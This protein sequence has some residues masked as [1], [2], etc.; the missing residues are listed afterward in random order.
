[1]QR[2]KLSLAGIPMSFPPINIVGMRVRVE[3]HVFW[4]GNVALTVKSPDAIA[5]VFRNWWR[6]GCGMKGCPSRQAERH[7]GSYLPSL[8]QHRLFR[9]NWNLDTPS[10]THGA[11]YGEAAGP[12]QTSLLENSATSK[13]TRTIAEPIRPGFSSSIVG[14]Q[15]NWCC[16][17]FMGFL[18][19]ES[20]R[21]LIVMDGG[22]G[23]MERCVESP[24][25]HTSNWA[26]R[27]PRFSR[28]API[29][30]IL[31]PSEKLKLS[32]SHVARGHPAESFNSRN[33]ANSYESLVQ[34]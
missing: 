23:F 31:L 10:L 34:V 4:L 8:Q 13:A 30:T 12:R 27:L 28:G 6:G 14:P 1:M 3:I 9:S 32:F 29:R 2:S 20:R 15:V 19:Q 33:D 5:S 24:P 11:F 16:D 18:S 25:T 21:C 7:R 17:R 22:E 26:R